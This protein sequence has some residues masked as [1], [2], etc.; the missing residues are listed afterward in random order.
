MTSPS[1]SQ[2]LLTDAA[3]YGSVSEPMLRRTDKDC[4]GRE[5]IAMAGDGIGAPR[6]LTDLAV[7]VDAYLNTVRQRCTVDTWAKFKQVKFSSKI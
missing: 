6:R 4:G 7:A 2:S 5:L 1:I 3:E